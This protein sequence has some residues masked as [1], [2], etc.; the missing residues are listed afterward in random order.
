M[1][2]AGTEGQRLELPLPFVEQIEVAGIFSDIG[3]NDQGVGT[4]GLWQGHGGDRVIPL[5]RNPWNGD[6][7]PLVV[8][9][10]DHVQHRGVLILVGQH[11]KVAYLFHL[12]YR[13]KESGAVVVDKPHD[14]QQQ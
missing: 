14:T 5:R 1:V 4:A 3:V 13:L 12:G 9:T 10:I 8:D 11:R 7:L 2:S 6:R